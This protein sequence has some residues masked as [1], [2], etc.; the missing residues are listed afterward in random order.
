MRGERIS[1]RGLSKIA[2]EDD[3]YRI[4]GDCI[5]HV[6]CGIEH[7]SDAQI[8]TLIA[9]YGL[10]E[11]L[12]AEQLRAAW[13]RLMTM[14]QNHFG[15]ANATA[16]ERAFRL[17]KDGQILIGSIDL[18]YQLSEKEVVLID[19]KTCPAGEKL[20]LNEDSK[21][22]AGKYSGQFAAYRSALSAANVDVKASLIYYPISGMLVEI[23]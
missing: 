11:I 13:N 14:L 16:H 8:T 9:S 10:A 3:R 21:L 1:V 20:I 2:S 7:L 15:T 17:H 5:H 22:Y 12:S 18:L 19:Y 4:V 6:F 23:K